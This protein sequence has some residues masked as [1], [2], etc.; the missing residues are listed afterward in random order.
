MSSWYA[1]WAF[2][3]PELAPV[4]RFMQ[5]QPV[6]YV[7]HAMGDRSGFNFVHDVSD[8]CEQLNRITPKQREKMEIIIADRA[9]VEPPRWRPF[10]ELSESGGVFDILMCPGA[11]DREAVEAILETCP[12]GAT[13]RISFGGFFEMTRDAEDPRRKFSEYITPVWQLVAKARERGLIIG[14]D[15]ERPEIDP[16]RCWMH[17]KYPDWVRPEYEDVVPAGVNAKVTP[18]PRTMLY[19]MRDGATLRE[20]VGDHFWYH[21]DLPDGGR[22]PMVMTRAMNRLENFGFIER[23]GELPP[24][25]PT[26]VMRYDW[27]I[28]AA[29]AAWL[30]ANDG[31]AARARRLARKQ[32]CVPN[33][34]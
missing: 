25:Y 12:D 34:E 18:E 33:R 8:W 32:G 5:D 30:A 28:S 16:M 11:A 2:A 7:M 15:R 29:G 26:K 14:E 17:R 24:G 31:Q 19:L 20:T 21:L 22:G 13:P 6:V 4:I 27:R 9:W 1:D 3:D 23:I 10:G